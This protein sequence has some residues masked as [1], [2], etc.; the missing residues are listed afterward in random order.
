MDGPGRAEFSAFTERVYDTMRDGFDGINRRLDLLNGR[1]GKTEVAA[2]K[3]DTRMRNVEHEVF[4]NPQRRHSDH[5]GEGEKWAASFTK[6][7]GGL[8]TLG[9]V[10]IYGLLRGLEVVGGIALK[11][12]M[13]H[14]P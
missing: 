4:R 3:L 10:V 6:R 9:F 8:I 2:G 11:L 12:L 5:A 14:R 1:T 7:E 13:A